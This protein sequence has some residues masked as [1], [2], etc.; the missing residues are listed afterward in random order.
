MFQLSTL[1]DTFRVAP[2]Q[3]GRSVEE[4]IREEIDAKYASRVI[5]EVGL[6]VCACAIVELGHGLVHPLDGC[7]TYHVTFQ[8]LM[9]R[10]F[11]GEVLAGTIRGSSAEGLFVSLDFFDSVVIP[12]TALPVPSH[13]DPATRIWTWKHKN[14]DF[15]LDLGHEVRVRVQSVQFTK[16]S[17]HKRGLRAT[18]T[19]ADRPRSASLD[20]DGWNTPRPVAMK[21]IA[22]IKREGLGPLSW[23]ET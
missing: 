9:F 23:W 7:A 5:L 4:V 6:C 11:V 22:D 2:S 13:Y 20:L 21:V 14:E 19:V 3:F 17:T 18:T 10:P 15:P 12:K 8:L 16:V 1:E